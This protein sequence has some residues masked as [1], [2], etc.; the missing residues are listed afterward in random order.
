MIDQPQIGPLAG[1]RV[2]EISMF[3]A[4]PTAGIMLA[5]LGA[6]VVKVERVPDGDD[7]R[8]FR[9]P[10]IGGE[11]AAFM[12]M[13][14]NKR[15]VAVDA[16][17]REGLEFLKSL[18]AS[19]DIVIENFRPGTLDRLGLGYET[20]A[21][22][23]PK[24]IYGTI[25]GYGLTGPEASR[26]GLDLIAQAF[27]G[28]MSI[29]GEGPGRPPVKVGA[30]VSDTTAGMLLALGVTAAYASAQ[31]TGN[32][33]RVDTSL[34]EAAIAHTY[35]QSAISLATGETPEPMGSAHPLSA[36]YQAFECT[37]GWLVVGAPN[38]LN[39]RRVVEALQLGSLADDPRF[40][41]NADRKAN[42]DALVALMAPAFARLSRSDCLDRLEAAGVP[43]G[44]VHTIPEM[45]AHEQTRARAMVT[46]VTHPRAGE[47][48]TLG[49]PIKF[50]G[51]P[52][53]LVRPAPRLGADNDLIAR[54][55]GYSEAQIE[56]MYRSGA[57]R[58]EH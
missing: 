42:L 45:L 58:R 38:D 46:R 15:G 57:L 4:G 23:N 18:C 7:S 35:W 12:M 39:F 10:E 41:T 37:D 3:M 2:V 53:G 49:C 50:S 22:L 24:L 47:V 31:R 51:T 25:S 13:N 21:E 27:S 28:L 29:T 55:L 19:A 17:S 14:R 11:S 40:L 5:D 48:E 32:G 16:K 36:P 30:P 52:S 1:V 20:L 26:P 44:P 54:E 8:R 56:A 6:E 43:C 9:P 33:Q 34:I